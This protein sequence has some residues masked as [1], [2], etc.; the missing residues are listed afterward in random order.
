MLGDVVLF[1]VDGGDNYDD[2]NVVVI[3]TTWLKI[4][5]EKKAKGKVSK[6]EFES[7]R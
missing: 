6:G 5:N 7:K 2:D 3:I 1:V 4:C